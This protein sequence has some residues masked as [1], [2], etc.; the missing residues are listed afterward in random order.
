[1]IGWGFER[2]LCCRTGG[3]CVGYGG[4][5]PSRAG[6]IHLV[7]GSDSRDELLEE[8]R[9]CAPRGGRMI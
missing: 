8:A 7:C 5:Y 4:V 9:G 1:L 3:L 6:F 2:R